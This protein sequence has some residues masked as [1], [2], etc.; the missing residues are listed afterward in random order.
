[1]TPDVALPVAAAE[2]P[3]APAPPARQRS[4]T[5]TQR[6]SL[7]AFASLLDYGVKI[8]VSL[9]VT[10]IL[11]TSLGRTLYGVW[12]MLAKLGSYMSATD[13][14]PTE[15]L[16]LIIAQRQ[17]ESDTVKR[18]HVSE[19]LVVWLITLPIVMAAGV[20]LAFWVAP[21]LTR[22]PAELTGEVRAATLLI[23][24]TF[25]LGGLAAIPESV[26]RGMNLGYRRMGL[27]ASLNILGGACAAAFVWLGWGLVGLGQAQIIRAVVTAVVFVLLVRRYVPWFGLERPNRQGVRSLLNM[28]VWL[29]AGDAI[30]KVMLASDVLIL[31]A[32]LAPAAV[33]T[34]ALT[35][36]A[37]RTA[38]GIHVFAAG[39]AIPGLGGLLGTR[40]FRRAAL[41]RRELLLLTWLFATVFG[42]LVLLWNRSFIGLW[43]GPQHYAGLLVDLLIVAITVQTVFIRTDAYVI[44]A[45]LRPR[46]RV[47][48]SALAAVLSIG[49]SVLAGRLVQT[50]AYPLLVRR[51]LG[52]GV[53]PGAGPF[54]AARKTAATLALFAA[55]ALLGQQ[56]E[57]STWILWAAGVAA[58]L[59][60]CTALA[61][62]LGPTGSERQALIGRLRT[63]RPGTRRP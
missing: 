7:T 35:G 57:A 21:A 14:R 9:V 31:G 60:A 23:A 6:A 11:V 55:A 61:L 30:A 25:I 3:A 8:I 20:V 12:E 33:T 19:A 63:L 62:V 29:T 38:A 15:A 50:V 16:R 40:Q 47:L 36:Y 2:A 22:V 52:A 48:V 34:Y 17:N 13:G 42:A 1:M 46:Q 56:L 45:T 26:L 37:A 59:A 24:A 53:V 51:D 49:L 28:S 27:Q 5:L 39:A 4:R 18:R 44:D 32:V 43:V 54:A 10:P 41:A 58:S